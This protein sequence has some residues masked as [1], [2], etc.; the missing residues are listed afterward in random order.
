MPKFSGHLGR[1]ISALLVVAL[2]QLVVPAP[3]IASHKDDDGGGQ[4]GGRD[5][6][7][8][9]IVC[10]V[11]WVICSLRC[12]IA[13]FRLHPQDSSAREACVGD[14]RAIC[15]DE[16]EECLLRCDA[17]EPPITPEEP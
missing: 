3:S 7:R 11:V 17:V 12:F 6:A 14:C 1:V 8:C 2:I 16:E 5:R 13:C 10:K 15:F 9:Q 4:N